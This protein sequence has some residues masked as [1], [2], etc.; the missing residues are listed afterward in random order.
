MKKIFIS[1]LC[2]AALVASSLSTYA[3]GAIPDHIGTDMSSISI[4]TQSVNLNVKSYFEYFQKYGNQYGV[5]PNLLAAICQQE[6]SGINWSHY[7]DGS[8]MPAWGIM[9]I[10]YTQEQNFANFGLETTGV[11]WTLEDRLD[12]EKSVAFAAKIISD[13]LIHYDCDYLKMIQGYNFSHYTLDKIIAAKGD[14]WMSERK[15]AKNYVKNWPYSSYG[16]KEYVEHVLTYYRQYMVYAGAKVRLNGNLIKFDRQFP[17]VIE[18]R[19]LI[20]IRGL[21]EKLGAEVSWNG[22]RNEATVKYNG[23]TIVIPIDADYTYVNGEKI[24]LDVSARV[25]NQRTMVPLRFIMNNFGFNVE[26]D[27]ETCTVNIN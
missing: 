25:I 18:D 26:W 5:D 19:T 13:L 4:G 15:N 6:S 10:E 12:P 23:T 21:F 9:Q 16:D 8:V 2:I 22:E 3:Q 17:L 24:S 20:P 14:D 11:K 1:L 7:K 27:Q